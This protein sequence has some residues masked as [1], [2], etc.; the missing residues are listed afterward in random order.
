MALAAILCLLIPATTLEAL[1]SGL[2][3]VAPRADKPVMVL[4]T[5]LMAIGGVIFFFYVRSLDFLAIEPGGTTRC[6]ESMSENL[7]KFCIN[8]RLKVADEVPTGGDKLVYAAFHVIAAGLVFAWPFR[9]VVRFGSRWL[10]DPALSH[11]VCSECG[12]RPKGQR[13]CCQA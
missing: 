1:H 2:S 7:K 4:V 10:L 12:R 13:P 11:V 5:I 8:G 3:K 6:W 9:F